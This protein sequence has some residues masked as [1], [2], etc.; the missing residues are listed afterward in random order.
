MADPMSAQ[1]ER[2]QIKQQQQGQTG[3]GS[4]SDD[5]AQP[6]KTGNSENGASQGQDAAYDAN[7]AEQQQPGYGSTGQSGMGSAQD[8]S[9][10]GM[11]SSAMGGQQAGE[12]G[13]AGYGNDTGTSAIGG[14][15]GG[16]QSNSD[17]HM[18][19]DEDMIDDDV[20]GANASS[21]GGSM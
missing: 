20:D 12:P 4:G 18:S 6:G 8:G 17:P 7:Q 9:D 11:G 16:Q 21:A 13:G 14:G 5:F 10:T 1:D 3:Y 2:D 15:M 19:D